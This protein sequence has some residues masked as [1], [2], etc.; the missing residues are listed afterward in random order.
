MNRFFEFSTAQLKGVIF[1]AA[2]LVALSAY[3]FVRSFSESDERGL[4]FSFQVG[5][6]DTRYEPVFKV[7]LNLSPVDSLELLPG[8]GP[9]LAERIAHYRDSAG[10]FTGIGDITK[11][12]GISRKLFDK[13]KPYLEV[14]SW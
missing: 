10:R 3:R 6:N 1:L 2:L 7:D 11:V 13:I 9:V 12:R 8:I 4:K 14:R 5:N